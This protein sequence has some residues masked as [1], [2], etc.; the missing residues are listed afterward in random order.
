MA[1]KNINKET[2]TRFLGQIEKGPR[3]SEEIP[4]ST[5]I[6]RVLSN[7]VSAAMDDPPYSNSTVDGYLLLTYGTAMAS[8][9][10][11][12]VFE[13]LGDIPVPSMAIELPAGKT[14]KVRRDSYM[15]I[16]RFL[17]GHYA[18]IK[19]SE[20][21]FSEKTKTV[22]VTRL[23]EKFENIVLQGSV[24]KV[25]NTIFKKG[26][27]LTDQDIITLAHQGISKVTVSSRPKVAIFSTGKELIAQGIPYIIGS[28]YDC[29]SYCLSAMVE[30]SFG[31]PLNQGIMQND[32]LPFM[33]KLVETALIADVI[34]MT[35][36]TRA[37]NGNFMSDLIKGASSYQVTDPAAVL[38][39]HR[40]AMLETGI[41]PIFLGVVSTKPVICLSGE[42]E[43][44]V[45]EFDAF[46]AP[47]LTHLSGAI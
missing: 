20:A 14:V 18:V 39:A 16:K 37:I 10:R 1:N 9:K 22:E 8:P 47:V 21:R 7:E 28:K 45:E 38:E 27:R 32:L 11:P 24:R 30:K 42:P 3:E 40:R 46:V 26:Y 2:L 12:M 31:L 35:G 5:A 15:A 19:E 25:G 6:G 33:K 23:V 34:V 43:K 44:I 41:K 4:I 36:A 13:S 17:E 29:N